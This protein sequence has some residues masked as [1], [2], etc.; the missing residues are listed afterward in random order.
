MIK[1]GLFVTRWH[2]GTKDPADADQMLDFCDKLGVTDIYVHCHEDIAV[3]DTW[4]YLGYVI[5]NR[6]KKSIYAW[7][8]TTLGR[9]RQN[10]YTKTRAATLDVKTKVIKGEDMSDVIKI[11][12]TDTKTKTYFEARIEAIKSVHPDLTGV[13]I[14][15]SKMDGKIFYCYTYSLK[16]LSEEIAKFD[17]NVY[18]YCYGKLSSNPKES[19]EDLLKAFKNG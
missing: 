18:L 4:D 13:Y 5:A 1:L 11:D 16:K 9:D 17:G 2:G 6:A 14:D 7:V 3:K 12:L 10:N 8:S 15:S 19:K